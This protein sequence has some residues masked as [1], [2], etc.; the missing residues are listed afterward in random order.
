MDALQQ[1]SEKYNMRINVKKTKVMR[2]PG[3]KGRR[4][5]I[6]VNDK[7]LEQVAQFC[8][9]GN[10]VTDDCRSEREIKRR[11]ALGKQAFI[12]KKDLVWIHQPSIEKAH[13]KSL[14]VWSIIFMEAKH[15][16]CKRVI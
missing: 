12:K 16:H 6:L 9:L 4:L 3:R 1:T 10:M 15:G 11:I 8:Y 13:S 5:I 14:C 7:E 2:I